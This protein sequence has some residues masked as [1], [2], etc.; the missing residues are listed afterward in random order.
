MLRLKSKGPRT[1]TKSLNKTVDDDGKGAEKQD[2]VQDKSQNVEDQAGRGGSQRMI[3]PEAVGHVVA[4]VNELHG[5]FTAEPT[6]KEL[7]EANF[8]TYGYL[9][10][11]AGVEKT[12]WESSVEAV[13]A[14]NDKCDLKHRENCTAAADIIAQKILHHLKFLTDQSS[15]DVKERGKKGPAG[16]R[17]KRFLSL[18]LPKDSKYDVV[19]S[20]KTI[21]D[22]QGNKRANN[23]SVK[24]GTLTPEERNR[25]NEEIDTIIE[26]LR[27]SPELLETLR[28]GRTAWSYMQKEMKAAA[29]KFK[30]IQE[31]MKAIKAFIRNIRLM[32]L[33]MHLSKRFLKL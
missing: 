30:Q 33:G 21:E 15:K 27:S 25:R 23:N 16:N 32:K 13:N 24:L 7:K 19:R 29:G 31:K 1:K 5:I 20:G 10:S 14:S 2:L 22:W 12:E 17:K 9:M 4:L 26:K 6:V 28:E 18:W 3:P 8:D 11:V